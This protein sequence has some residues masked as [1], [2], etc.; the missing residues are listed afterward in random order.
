MYLNRRVFVMDSEILVMFNYC[1]L[2]EDF[3][4]QLFYKASIISSNFNFYS[5]TNNRNRTIAKT[6][7]NILRRT[8]Y[9]CK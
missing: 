4:T 2:Y 5:P 3:R 1:R 7:F 6:C 8:V 9:L